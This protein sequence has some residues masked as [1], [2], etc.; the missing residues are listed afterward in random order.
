VL[1]N[2]MSKS[3]DAKS[4][5]GTYELIQ[6]GYFFKQPVSG[7]ENNFKPIS[8]F[9]SG[10]IH[11]SETGFMSVVLRFAEKPAEFSDIVAYSGTYKVIENQIQHFVTMSV[12]PEYEGQ[13]L[14][15]VFKLTN[16]ILELEFENTDEFRKVALW[17]K[18]L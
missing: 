13:K 8:E 1:E 11:Y 15:R 7:F 6:Y 5:F 3:A 2:N 14:D 18:L 9:Y 17:K 12:R 16:D 10:S 4:I